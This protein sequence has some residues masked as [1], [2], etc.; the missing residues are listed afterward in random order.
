MEQV[1][2]AK[3]FMQDCNI[4]ASLMK[5]ISKAVLRFQGT[6]CNRATVVHYLLKSFGS[7]NKI[8]IDLPTASSYGKI[9]LEDLENVG[10]QLSS[11]CFG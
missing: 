6:D 2:T 11:L 7:I 5:P 1:K 10:Y 8:I 4:L 9:S 3:S